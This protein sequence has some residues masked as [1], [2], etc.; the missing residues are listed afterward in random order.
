[1]KS[2]PGQ[3]APSSSVMAQRVTKATRG[4][5][6]S[7]ER[8]AAIFRF[9]GKIRHGSLVRSGDVVWGDTRKIGE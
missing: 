3:A 6:G 4:S 1:M 9:A 7:S 2:S 8:F 5:C